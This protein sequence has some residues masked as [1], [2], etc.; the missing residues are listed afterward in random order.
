[1]QPRPSPEG[2]CQ[3]ETVNSAELSTVSPD[4]HPRHRPNTGHLSTNGHR[5]EKRQVKNSQL[6]QLQR[7]GPHLETLPETSE[8]TDSVDRID[9][10]PPQEPGG[11]GSGSSNG[12]QRD[13]EKGR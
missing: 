12:C 1:M 3:A 6:L 10:D 7:E 4:E 2:V 5:P 11:Q 8:A 9:R 13:R